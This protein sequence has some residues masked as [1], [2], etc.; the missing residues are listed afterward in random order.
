MTSQITDA[1]LSYCRS[2]WIFFYSSL[3]FFRKKLTEGSPYNSREE[4]RVRTE[5]EQ[6]K[7]CKSLRGKMLLR[8]TQKTRNIHLVGGAREFNSSSKRKHPRPLVSENCADS[9]GF[10]EFG[11]LRWGEGAS[12]EGI[13]R[14]RYAGKGVRVEMRTTSIALSVPM[15]VKLA[16]VGKR[17]AKIW[18]LERGPDP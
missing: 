15:P 6:R 8:T 5:G 17:M 14:T 18:R 4:L 1:Y 2:S 7:R 13:P 16:E 10:E 12:G 9:V 3:F 11:I